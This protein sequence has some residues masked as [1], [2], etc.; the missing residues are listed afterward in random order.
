MCWCIDK[1]FESHILYKK[2][3]IFGFGPAPP[4][5]LLLLTGCS[6]CGISCN[7]LI[8]YIVHYI[9]GN[10]SRPICGPP[11]T[12]YSIVTFPARQLTHGDGDTDIG[13]G[14]LF[15][16]IQ[17]TLWNGSH[18]DSRPCFSLGCYP[19]VRVRVVRGVLSY[20]VGQD[21]DRFISWRNWVIVLN[22]FQQ[23]CWM[24]F[25]QVSPSHTYIVQ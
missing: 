17:S 24:W 2:Y 23:G 14:L 1:W 16:P 11:N 18:F 6:H 5:C 19:G 15:I 21:D 10:L 8:L 13:G 25:R 12:Q 4:L 9:L 22:V 3:T 20:P 7:I